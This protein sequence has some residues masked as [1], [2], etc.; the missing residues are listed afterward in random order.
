MI[1]ATIPQG[2]Q[3]D[4]PVPEARI[5]KLVRCFRHENEGCHRCD[6]SGHRP[7]G[8]APGAVISLADPARGARPCWWGFATIEGGSALLLSGLSPRAEPWFDGVRGDG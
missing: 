2:G 5:P 1:E 6:G 3:K 4:I 7:A 8:T